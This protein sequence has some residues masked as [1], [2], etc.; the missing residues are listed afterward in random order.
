VVGHA[1]KCAWLSNPTGP[2]IV[3]STDERMQKFTLECDKI[4]AAHLCGALCG[5]CSRAAEELYSNA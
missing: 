2:P 1:L 3:N 4:F 5:R